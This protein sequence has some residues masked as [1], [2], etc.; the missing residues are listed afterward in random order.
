MIFNTSL[1]K[2]AVGITVRGGKYTT[3][4]PHQAENS[5]QSGQGAEFLTCASCSPFTIWEII[6]I[7]YCAHLCMKCFLGV[8]NF[9]EEISSLSY[10][11]IFLYF[12]ALITEK[13]LLISPCYS[14]ELCVQMG[15]SF[16]FSFAFS[17]SPFLSYL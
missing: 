3:H 13:G 5:M 1:E 7:L 15:K 11:I 2:R 14:L 12:F 9:L 8:S 6:S 17:V 16:P 4:P 10:S